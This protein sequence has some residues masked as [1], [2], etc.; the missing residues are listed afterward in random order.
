MH[1]SVEVHSPLALLRIRIRMEKLVCRK[2]VIALFR[3]KKIENHEN[4]GGLW[5][6]NKFWKEGIHRDEP[7]LFSNKWFRRLELFGE[8]RMHRD[9]DEGKKHGKR[10]RKRRKHAWWWM[11]TRVRQ[12]NLLC[13]LTILSI[14]YTLRYDEKILF[15][16]EIRRIPRSV[17]N[18][19]CAHDQVL[20]IGASDFP[21][22]RLQ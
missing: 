5:E 1:A 19:S 20:A 17:G 10:I 12:W 2:N 11:R 7:R 14:S 16:R 3:E 18:T 9:E 6:D 13:L 4:A 8:M 21:V 15:P 22:H